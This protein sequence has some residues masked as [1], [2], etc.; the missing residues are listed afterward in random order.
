VKKHLRIEER[1]TLRRS[2]R[3]QRRSKVIRITILIC[4]LFSVPG[5]RIQ[6]D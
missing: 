6:R 5:E 1:K 2:E 3:D 4:S